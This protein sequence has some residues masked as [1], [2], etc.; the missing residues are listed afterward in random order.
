MHMNLNKEEWAI[1]GTLLGIGLIMDFT[2]LGIHSARTILAF[3]TCILPIQIAL[4]RFSFSFGESI[5]FSY[6]IV[7][8]V[9]PTVVWG[10]GF[11]IPFKLA[12]IVSLL[13]FYMIFAATFLSIKKD[14]DS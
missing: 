5:I 14:K 2:L 7:I 12:T 11:I 9:L 8:T 10:L 1:Y 6:I 3:V 13:L 4:Q